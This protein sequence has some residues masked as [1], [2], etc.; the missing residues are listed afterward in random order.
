MALGSSS[1]CVVV[2]ARGRTRSA[3]VRLSR[4]C[5]KEPYLSSG[6]R[7]KRPASSCGTIGGG[8]PADNV[9]N[10]PS[11]TDHRAIPATYADEWENLIPRRNLQKRRYYRRGK[12]LTPSSQKAWR[13]A[14]GFP[15][16]MSA[17]PLPARRKAGSYG[18]LSL[19]DRKSGNSQTA[20]PERD[21]RMPACGRE[22]GGG[23]VIKHSSV[24]GETG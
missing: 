16:P 11:R 22:D 17:T 1:P 2:R 18:L 14:H 20:S 23:V 9:P 15:G 19:L 8:K 5:S 24:M 6:T 21:A 7:D 10:E 13:L 3:P 12:W 4:S